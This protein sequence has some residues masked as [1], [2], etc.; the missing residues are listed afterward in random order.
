MGQKITDESGR[1][2]QYGRQ[3][4]R[5][6]SNDTVVKGGIMSPSEMEEKAAALFDRLVH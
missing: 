6:S 3:A 4:G 5:L 2:Q 1:S